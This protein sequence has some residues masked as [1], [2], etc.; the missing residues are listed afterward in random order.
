LPQAKVEA[1]KIDAIN[2]EQADFAGC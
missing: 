2:D 1:G